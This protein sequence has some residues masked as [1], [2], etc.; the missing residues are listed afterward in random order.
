MLGGDVNPYPILLLVNYWEFKPSSV[1][2]QLDEL[3]KRG[4]SQVAS[5]VPWQVAESDISHALTRFL[6]AASE[7]K[8]AVYLILTPEVGIHYP[9]SG[10]PKD[11]MRKK[12]NYAQHCHMGMITQGLPPN[13]FQVPSLFSPELT[14]RYFSYLSKMDGYFHDLTQ[15]QPSLMARTSLVLTGSFWKYYRSPQRS[16]RHAFGGLAGDYSQHASLAYRQ[17]VEQYFAQREF[18]D[19]TPSAANRWKSRSFDELNRKWF[20]QQSEDVF[21]TRSYQTLRRKSSRLKII[22]MELFT[23]EAD[24]S[25]TYSSFLQLMAGSQASAS[26]FSALMDQ[27]SRRVSLGASPH[28][29]WIHWTSLKDFRNLSEPEKQFLFLKSLLLTGGQGG[30]VLMDATEWLSFSP[31]FRTRAEAIARSIS[32]RHLKLKSKA[33]YLVPHLWSPYGG[34]W[35]QLSQSLGHEVKLT[36]S[37]DFIFKEHASK[38]L[39]VDP[40]CIIYRETLQKLLAWAKNGR[41]VVL[42]Q[43]Q[44]Y[45]EAAH[46][47][48]QLQL[49]NTQKMEMN[50]QFSYQLYSLG[51]GKLVTYELPDSW[52]LKSGPL[53]SWQSFLQAMISLAEVGKSYHF[54]APELEVIPLGLEDPH[55]TAFF[56]LNPHSQSVQA[57]LTFT[58]NVRVSDLGGALLEMVHA[59]QGEASIHPAQVFAL[60]VPALGVVPLMVSDPEAPLQKST[61]AQAVSLEK[62]YFTEVRGSSQAT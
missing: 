27:S 54:S 51:E 42:P 61:Q 7:R 12:E 10:L 1:G 39:I 3:M 53:S 38:L 29:P 40:S 36:H 41:V 21:R 14:K 23:P 57:E 55:R 45:T 49:R 60:E 56:V 52:S 32:E 9:F 20:Y 58:Q 8:L 22:E 16:A 46:R 47:E 34:A 19:P 48:L 44:F 18:L 59:E 31:S 43:S 13:Y 26:Q 35:D 4:V 28:L 37:M 17:R 5:F 33:F 15:A 11:I 2:A 24:P 50:L 25:L 6:L 30:G 62:S